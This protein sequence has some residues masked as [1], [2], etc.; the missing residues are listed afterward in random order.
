MASRVR[1][2][3]VVAAWFA[4]NI[5]MGNLNGWILKHHGFAY[6]AALTMVH[7]VVGWA[8][9]SSNDR[10]LA[11]SA[12]QKALAARKPPPGLIHHSV[13]GSP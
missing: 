11:L 2:W 3:L 7:M 6:P 4:L 1:T 5:T 10:A 13:R 8:M 12:L 9:S